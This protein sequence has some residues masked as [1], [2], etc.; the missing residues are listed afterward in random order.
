M[1]ESYNGKG[2]IKLLHSLNGKEEILRDTDILQTPIRE[3]LRGSLPFENTW[4]ASYSV[5]VYTNLWIKG[6]VIDGVLTDWTRGEDCVVFFLCSPDVINASYADMD[7]SSN[8]FMLLSIRSM[9]HTE[10]MFEWLPL[11]KNEY[12]AAYLYYMYA[13]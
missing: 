8:K 7:K 1:L 6:L 12:Y 2:N 13:R 9:V 4:T 10:D 5:E 11:T 3:I